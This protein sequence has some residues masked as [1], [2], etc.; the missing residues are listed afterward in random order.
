MEAKLCAVEEDNFAV[1]LYVT[2]SG[3][4]V[5][6]ANYIQSFNLTWLADH[7]KPGQQN[8]K[9]CSLHAALVVCAAVLD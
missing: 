6:F 9:Q 7:V 3:E 2:I 8:R 5:M 1:Y 4:K